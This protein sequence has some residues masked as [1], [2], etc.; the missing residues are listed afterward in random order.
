[1]P[2]SRQI[3]AGLAATLA[4]ALAG[5]APAADLNVLRIIPV[6]VEGGAASLYITPQGHSLLI[7]TGFPAGAGGPRVAPDAPPPPPTSSSAERIASAAFAAG[8]KRIDYLLLSHY[9]LDHIGGAPELMK[10]IPIGTLIDHGPARESPRP[11]ATPAQ[12]ANSPGTRYPAFLALMGDR[13]HRVMKPGDTLKIDDLLLTA[14]D[15]DKEIPTRP[16]A[17]SGAPGFNCAATTTNDNIGGEE[18]ARS[19]GIAFSWGRARVLSLGDTTWNLENSL[20]CPRDLIGPVDLMFIDNH[21]TNNSNSPQL[22]NTVKPTVMVL[23]NGPVKGADAATFDTLA[24][25][26]SIKGVW[27]VHFATRSPEKN[28]P[29]DQIANLDG[30]DLIF[31]LQIEVRK[32]GSVKMINPRNDF[33]RTYP[34]AAGR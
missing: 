5:T 6:D 11:D 1:M 30:R 24:A 17:G 15:S 28:A 33:T 34:K 26:P 25:V 4:I 7:D 3:R 29:A 31:P 32:D 20:V 2:F 13:P 21:G 10:L 19:L 22:I 12:A 9:H 8:L 16:I 27:Q 14:V 18:N 23:N